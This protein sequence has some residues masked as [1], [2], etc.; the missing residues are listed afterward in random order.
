[1]NLITCCCNSILQEKGGWVS[2]C[3]IERLVV[4]IK[5]VEHSTGDVNSVEYFS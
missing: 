4:R 2:V 1:M 3:G 5:L